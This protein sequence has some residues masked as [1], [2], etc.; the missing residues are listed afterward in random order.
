MK[1]SNPIKFLFLGLLIILSIIAGNALQQ[2]ETGIYLLILGIICV[3]IVA[4]LL[5][6]TSVLTTVLLIAVYSLKPHPAILYTC[7][8][9][10]VFSLMIELTRKRF[11]S[12][13]IP[14][15][16]LLSLLL[17][18]GIQSIVRAKVFADG[19]QYFTT[20]ILVP[21]ITLLTIGNAE[22]K[23]NQLELWTKFIVTV[24]IILSLIGIVM[25]I[26]NPGLRLG[27]LWIT[28][29]TING[30]YI[31]AFFLTI[32]LM[33]KTDDQTKKNLLILGAICIF[34]GMLYTYTR[35]TLLAVAF[36]FIVLMLKI[37][38]LRKILFLFILLTP[39]VIPSSMIQRL[40]LGFKS[41]LSLIIRF[42]AW[43][44]AFKLIVKNF[45]LGIGFNT[46]E[47]I[48]SS[49]IPYQIL[50]AKHPHNT[51]LRI[52]V[53]TGVFGFLAYFGLVISIMVKFFKNCISQTGD[54]FNY[55][56]FTA[57]LAVLFAC[58]TDVFIQQVGVSLPFW[59]TLALM[60]QQSVKEHAK[61]N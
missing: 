41:D 40:Q 34:L 26:L 27:S 58:L 21:V 12:F 23:N 52:M 54:R 17:I 5:F 3:W 6:E 33:L 14:Y 55:A 45:W 47:H 9:L 19:F 20:T 50:Y 56:V 16:I 1:I 4:S 57:V 18:T 8:I 38:N 32:G 29:M 30:F 28:A 36:G 59:I 46:W 53:E 11:A 13:T 43:Y 25:A 42:I 39:L 22:Y 24:G 44:N 48:Y 35:I 15:P 2:I 60:Y 49:L 31:L 10:L 37:K 51:Y 61:L 7:L